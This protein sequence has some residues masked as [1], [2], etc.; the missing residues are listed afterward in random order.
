MYSGSNYLIVNKPD[1]WLINCPLT[2]IKGL[3]GKPVGD[4][5]PLL[6]GRSLAN[7]RNKYIK[8][9]G[10]PAP[11]PPPPTE[12][13]PIDLTD[14]ARQILRVVKRWLPERPLVVV[15]GNSFAALELLDAVREAVTVVTRL[16]LDAVLYA[17]APNG[18][19]DTWRAYRK[20]QTFADVHPHPGSSTDRVAQGRGQQL[21]W[22]RATYS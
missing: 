15:A 10:I 20:G 9:S 19:L 16:R 7:L 13:A 14:R 5:A 18:S 21:V 4:I 22:P 3:E 11:E 12:T 17:P 8:A 6:F 2:R 1:W